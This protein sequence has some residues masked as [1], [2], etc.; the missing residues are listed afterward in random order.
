MNVNQLIIQTLSSHGPVVPD[1]YEGNEKKYLTFN[2]PNE[3]GAV[4]GDNHP[5]KL[6][7][8]VQIHLFL[9]EFEEYQ[10]EKEMICRE[11]YSV[12]FLWPMVTI[13]REKDTQMRHLVFE[14]QIAKNILMEDKQCLQD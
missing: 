12:G 13:V 5:H 10:K 8:D 4:Y 2:F 3:Q 14:T 11:L 9:G 6:I 7:I 1:Y